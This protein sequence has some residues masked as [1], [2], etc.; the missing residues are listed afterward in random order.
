LEIKKERSA[1]QNEGNEG[2]E[3][4]EANEGNEGNEEEGSG[5]EVESGRTCQKLLTIN[6]EANWRNGSD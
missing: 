2:N 4:N 1:K 5:S 3:G 6:S